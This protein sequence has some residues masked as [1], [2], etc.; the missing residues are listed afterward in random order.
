MEP[1]KDPQTCVYGDLIKTCPLGSNTCAKPPCPWKV[2][3]A[4][5]VASFIKNTSI[6]S[7]V[8][9]VLVESDGS[10]R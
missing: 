3:F 10:V 6:W 2:M 4:N 7:F 1:E 9:G 5:L 8:F